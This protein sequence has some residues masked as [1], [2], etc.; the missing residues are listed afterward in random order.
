V[1]RVSGAGAALVVVAFGVSRALYR[2]QGVRF[3]VSPLGYFAQLLEPDLLR[4]RL[5]PS[6]LHLHAQP[7]LYN[8]VAGVALKVSHDRPE[9]ILGPLY[10]AVG[11]YAGL[12]LYALLCRLRVS[13]WLASA[14]ASA[15][16][17][18][19]AFVLYE[20]W[21]FYPH[22]NVAW[23]LGAAAWFAES[24][25]RP[26]AAMVV[27][28]LHLAG[29]V[30]TRSLFHPLF[31]LLA[32][33]VVVAL[34]APGTRRQVGAC[35]ALSG[36][37][38]ALWCVKNLVLFGFFGTSS[39][40]SRNISK[41]VTSLLGPGLVEAEV[42]RRALSPAGTL[43]PFAPGHRTAA[44]FGLSPPASG[45]PALIRSDKKSSLRLPVNYNHWSY[46][47]TARSYARDAYHLVSAYPDT[48][49]RGLAHE[50]LPTF[51]GPVDGDGFVAENRKSIPALADAFD[52]FDTSSHTRWFLAVGLLLSLL[53][54]RVA[55]RAERLP[56][57]FGFVVMTWVGVIGIVGD[58]G[59]N[60]RFRYKV[61]W[62][63]WA[64]AVAGYSA[65]LVSAFRRLNDGVAVRKMVHGRIG[66][67]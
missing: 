28:G 27:A 23:L 41:N 29:L 39:W 1:V 46:P 44:A 8:L 12:C 24:R 38:I 65:V 31:F 16:V 33:I 62:L 53:R 49:L 26:G 13:V 54:L 56:I 22:L 34:A 35:L 61:L 64:L 52:A 47:A 17:S 66:L 25:G 2:A 32:A 36:F 58:H 57:A 10:A 45:E 20:N 11:L 60:Y 14:L 15:I 4:D 7:P 67:G 9:V 63:A 3:D 55:S 48:F 18:A 6:L 30:L 51:L 59:E 19:P 5:A 21:F 42:R 50:N 37:L 40:A 43:G